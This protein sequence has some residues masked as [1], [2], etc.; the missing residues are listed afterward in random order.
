MI[1]HCDEVTIK[2]NREELQYLDRFLNDIKLIIDED[3]LRGLYS[4]GGIRLLEDIVFF[5]KKDFKL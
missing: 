2:L 5:A 4:H 1:T 3:A